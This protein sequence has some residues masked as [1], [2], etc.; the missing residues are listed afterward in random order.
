MRECLF[1]CF[2]R[3]SRP[4]MHGRFKYHFFLSIEVHNWLCA[5]VGGFVD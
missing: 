5:F 4:A 1:A 3:V 2:E